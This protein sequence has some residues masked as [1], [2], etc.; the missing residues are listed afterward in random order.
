MA[1]HVLALAEGGCAPFANFAVHVVC[2]KIPNPDARTPD[3]VGPIVAR[4]IV[5][6][7][8]TLDDESE[9]VVR[10][11]LQLALVNAAFDAPTE[12]DVDAALA[13]VR[14]A[15]NV[16]PRRAPAQK[17]ASERL[18]ESLAPVLGMT[19]ARFGAKG[20]LAKEHAIS[21]SD[22]RGKIRDPISVGLPPP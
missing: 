15:L 2:V 1:A 8:G 3:A 19:L 17:S 6:W 14:V 16:A 22:G 4:V 11:V 9:T 13:A 21:L 5:S 20:A 10:G 12:A 7:S 18:H